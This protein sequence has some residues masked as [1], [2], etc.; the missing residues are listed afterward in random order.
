[1]DNTMYNHMEEKNDKPVYGMKW[2]YFLIWF[3]LFF[4]AIINIVDGI[5]CLEYA[6][7]VGGSVIFRNLGNRA[8]LIPD[9][10][11]LSAFGL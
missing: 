9:F 2:H 4:S 1:M 3:S 7:E 10:R 6:G 8:R 11:T 5:G